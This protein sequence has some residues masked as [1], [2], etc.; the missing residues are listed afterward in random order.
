MRK[1]VVA[2]GNPGKAREI[3]RILSNLDFEVVSLADY[4]SAPEPEENAD[5]FIGNA[6]IKALAVA[7]R[8]G[9][10]AIADDS[11]LAIDALDGAPGVYSSR[12]AGEGATDEDRN[13]KVLEML[14]DVP[15]GERS[16]RFISA[17]AI[18]E[19]G[20]LI[21]TVEGTCEGVIAHGPRGS[22]GF[23]YDP[24]FYVRE[25]GRMMAELSPDEKNEISHRGRALEKAKNILKQIQ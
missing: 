12:F 20:Q 5:S 13:E 25:L 7:E 15:D 1:L 10:L 3:A 18:A 6:A 2:T 8:T 11:G 19:P 14:K 23:G 16:A 22:N 9:E 24:I 17:I 4:P 21:G